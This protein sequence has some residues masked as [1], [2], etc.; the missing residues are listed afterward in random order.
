MELACESH[1][2]NFPVEERAWAHNGQLICPRARDWSAPSQLIPCDI[3]EAVSSFA[4][5]PGRKEIC[6]MTTTD[7]HEPCKCPCHDEQAV[8]VFGSIPED[9]SYCC[10]V[11]QEE[12]EAEEK[13]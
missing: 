6:T 11:D 8:D 7:T 10:L 1:R 12:R 13:Q 3:H 2:L 5:I 9:C 4:P